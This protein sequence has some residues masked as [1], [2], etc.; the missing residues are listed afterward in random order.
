MNGCQSLPAIQPMDND[1]TILARPMDN[2]SIL[3][4]DTIQD[5][6]TIIA[7]PI[8]NVSIPDAETMRAP[9]SRFE[10]QIDWSNQQ[11]STCKFVER[12]AVAYLDNSL[13][14]DMS[15]YV[16]W[17]NISVPAHS[18]IVAAAS[19]VLERCVYG[20]GDIVNKERIIH[21]RN[22]TLAEFYVLLRY[23]YTGNSN[24]G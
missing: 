8:D 14:S 5:Q 20:T 9:S 16:D 17:E 24:S 3:D 12:L 18:L 19:P 4:D 13:H 1:G 10:S 22:C 15:F 21:V 2:D 23:I 7:R 11:M 6:E